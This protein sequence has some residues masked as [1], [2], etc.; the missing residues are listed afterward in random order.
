MRRSYFSIFL[1][2]STLFGCNYTAPKQELVRVQHFVNTVPALQPTAYT[3]TEDFETG[4]KSNYKKADVKLITGSWTFKDALI[5]EDST[6]VKNGKKSVRLRNGFIGM[7]FDLAEV[8][9]ISIKHSKYGKDADAKWQLYF[10]IDSGSTYI[11]LGK[12]VTDTATALSTDQFSFNINKPARFKLVK[13]GSSRINIDDITFK[14]SGDAGILMGIPEV[15]T[16]DTSKALPA[17]VRGVV[18]GK[19]APPVTGDNSNMLFGNPSGA[20]TVV[21]MADNYLMDMGYYIESYNNSKSCP[22]WV[23]WHLDAANINNTAPRLDNF[24]AYNGLPNGWFAVK[25]NSYSY[26]KYGFDR[27]HNCPSADRTSST[28]ANAATFLMTNM[29]PQAPNNNQHTWGNFEDYLRSLVLQGNEVYVIM[30][31]YGTGGTGAKGYFTN[32]ASGTN[33][34]NVPA[35]I[36][37]VALIIPAGNN[38]LQR[39]NAA[40]RIIAINT[41][42]NNNVNNRWEYYLVS[43]R[44]IEMATGYN[45]FSNLPQHL[46]DALENNKRATALP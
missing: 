7:N 16:P 14:G 42:N 20:Q 30:G 34:I 1:L 23:S 39:V 24:A 25:N 19:D 33:K 2:V 38:D 29:I 17:A 15:Q 40:T 9:Q 10:S 26:N 4:E 21:A 12:P 13:N 27:G 32:I 36:W 35:N 22:N 5:G 6:D 43:V 11:P 3:I 46:Q 8:K 28:N 41:P 45:L 37:K 18:I 31:S 44:D